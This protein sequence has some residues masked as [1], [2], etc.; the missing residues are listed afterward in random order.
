MFSLK[1][2]S[3]VILKMQEL[4]GSAIHPNIKIAVDKWYG[5]ILSVQSRR[6]DE[7]INASTRQKLGQP[8]I[9]DERGITFFTF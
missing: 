1:K 6:R 5:S 8:R 3:S 7:I 4:S 2:V 9:N